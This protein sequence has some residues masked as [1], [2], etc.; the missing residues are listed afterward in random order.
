MK[1]SDSRQQSHDVIQLDDQNNKVY[2][3][4]LYETNQCK[5]ETFS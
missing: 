2:H 3:R 4:S 1:F 5:E